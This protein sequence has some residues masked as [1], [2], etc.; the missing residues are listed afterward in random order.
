MNEGRAKGETNKNLLSNDLEALKTLLIEKI[1][2]IIKY[3]INYV[4]VILPL[5]ARDKA[6]YNTKV[7]LSNDMGDCIIKISEFYCT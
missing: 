5:N 6:V 3:N 4:D 7:I 1:I 2:C